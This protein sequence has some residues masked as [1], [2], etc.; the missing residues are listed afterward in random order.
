MWNQLVVKGGLCCLG[1]RGRVASSK[2]R[3]YKL[4]MIWS[5]NQCYAAY[6]THIRPSTSVIGSLRLIYPLCF[7][8]GVYSQT[9]SDLGLRSYIHCT[10]NTP[11]NH[12]LYITESVD[13]VCR[14]GIKYGTYVPVFCRS[15]AIYFNAHLASWQ[16]RDVCCNKSKHLPYIV[17]YRFGIYV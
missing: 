12:G 5:K 11:S 15:L 16:V 13:S 17:P 7:A 9:S 4:F 14:D 8:F 6:S 2:H 10:R 3:P 1:A